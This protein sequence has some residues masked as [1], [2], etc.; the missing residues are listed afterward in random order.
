MRRLSLVE[1]RRILKTIASSPRD[2]GSLCR[3]TFEFMFYFLRFLS[4]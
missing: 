4:A 1:R 3:D 2:S